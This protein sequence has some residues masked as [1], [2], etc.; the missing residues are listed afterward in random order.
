[1]DID[2]LNVFLHNHSDS[3]HFLQSS[4]LYSLE[5]ERFDI[6]IFRRPSVD[7]DRTFYCLGIWALHAVHSLSK[8]LV[9]AS[10]PKLKVV[11]KVPQ[12]KSRSQWFTVSL[13]LHRA[14]HW[15]SLNGLKLIIPHFMRFFFLQNWKKTGYVEVGPRKKV[16]WSLNGT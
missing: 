12:V 3:F 9:S 8:G 16:H 6:Y 5:I 10:C 2:W 7:R 11:S 14:D 1:M 4:N 13:A 15:D